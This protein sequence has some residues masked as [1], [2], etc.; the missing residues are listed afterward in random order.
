MRRSRLVAVAATA[1]SLALVAVGAARA[2]PAASAAPAAAAPAAAPVAPAAPPTDLRCLIVFINLAESD[3]PQA[4]QIGRLGLIYFWGRLQGHG[5]TTGI[6]DRLIDEVTKMTPDDLKTDA[7]TC[8]GELNAS[9]KTL[10]DVGQ[11]L[12]Q[13]IQAA[14]AAA[15]A[16]AAASAPAGKS[17]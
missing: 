17:K 1:A 4:K 7:D 15:A 8:G 10:S 2:Q 9:I 5:S 11:E 16:A 14:Q 6:G 3:D 13:R 12:G